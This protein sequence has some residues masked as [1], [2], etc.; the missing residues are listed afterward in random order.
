MPTCRDSDVPLQ[1]AS[2]PY[3]REDFEHRLAGRLR[4]AA[5]GRQSL[6]LVGGG[7]KDF[8]GN[9]LC[10]EPLVL[11]ELATVEAE[12]LLAAVDHDAAELV[13]TAPALLPLAMLEQVLAAAGQQLPFEPPRFAAGGTVGGCVAAGLSGPRRRSAGPWQG[14]VRDFLLGA[15]VVDG[16]GRVLTPGGRVMKN[17]A[18]FD[19]A[20]AM[21]GS[22]GILGVL[23]EVSIKVLPVP[24][25]ERTLV[26]EVDE[27]RALA[28][29]AGWT[30]L[31][32]PVSATAWRTGRLWVRLAGAGS[33]VA[34][35]A[36][37]LGGQE[38]AA[39]QAPWE[40]LRDQTDDWFQAPGALWRCSLPANAPSLA[41][42]GEQVIEWGGC[43]RWLRTH[44]SAEAVRAR[45]TALGGHATLFRGASPQ[46]RVAGVFTPL[47]P[48]LLHLHARL[49]HEFDPAGILNPGRL[50]TGL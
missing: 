48:A 34:A 19:L 8:L 22:F 5:A 42:P 43:Q 40:S 41:L 38:V 50:V 35:A 26:F 15:R 17:V 20:R 30:S 44:S 4:A 16:Q 10:G 2:S 14:S 37:V 11:R 33:A 47:P 21:A 36:S 31:P 49:K 25:A 13:V 3:L 46:Q 6:R 45:V 1:A 39:A 18:G 7:T 29:T 12:A 32:L 9:A 27:A 23:T 24:P 28:M